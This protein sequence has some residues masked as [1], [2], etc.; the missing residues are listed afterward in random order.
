MAKTIIR[1]NG[2]GGELDS[3]VLDYEAATTEAIAEAAIALIQ[4]TGM[5]LHEG[6]SITVTV[7]G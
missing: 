7:E 2:S 6:D 4:S 5:S 3:V 1:L